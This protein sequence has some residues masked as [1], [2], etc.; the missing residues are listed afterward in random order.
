MAQAFAIAE[1]FIVS[2]RSQGALVIGSELLS[3]FHEL[4]SYGSD[5]EKGHLVAT[6]MFGDGAGVVVLLPSQDGDSGI[7][8]CMF[9]SVGGGRAPGMVLKAGGALSPAGHRELADG[10][11]FVHDF[12]AILERGPELVERG[13]E[14]VWNSGLVNAGELKYCVP[15]QVS[16]HL[17]ET[18]SAKTNL[19]GAQ[20]FSNFSRVGNTASAS[21]YIALDEMSR[22][23]RLERGDVIVLLPA[24]ATKW[25]YGAIVLRW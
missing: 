15:P 2:G 14:W 11:A 10:P 1:Q 25:T 6:A 3:P 16:G 17:I 8:G 19:R 22:D 18:M 12:R 5:T 24:E 7:L 4:L 9:R 21:I 20:S 13:L 23:K